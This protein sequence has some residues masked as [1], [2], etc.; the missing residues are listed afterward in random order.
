MYMRT[1]PLMKIWSFRKRKIHIRYHC[2]S[3]IIDTCILSHVFRKFPERGYFKHHIDMLC[4][5]ANY[6]LHTLRRERKYSTLGKAKLLYN[7]FINSQFNYL[8][9]IWMFCWKTDCLK[10]ETT[11]YKALK[12]IYNSNESYD[13]LLTCIIESASSSNYVLWLQK[14]MGLVAI[15]FYETIIYKIDV[16]LNYH[17]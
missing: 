6:K 3:I 9:L 4:S 16:P 11:Q 12:F 5:T 2:T 8:S 17:Q 15:G 13:K 1:I 10:I 14:Y 7:A